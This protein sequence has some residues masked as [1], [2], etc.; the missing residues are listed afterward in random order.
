VLDPDAGSGTT[1]VAA[2]RLGRRWLLADRSPEAFAIARARLA[3]E[4]PAAG[5]DASTS[6]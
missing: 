1:G 3:A 2:Q 6:R 5:E 4:Q